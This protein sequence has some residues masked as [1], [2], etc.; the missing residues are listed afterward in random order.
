M[1]R[2]EFFPN[3]G[4]RSGNSRWRKTVGGTALTGEGHSDGSAGP[5]SYLI[6]IWWDDSAKTYRFFTCF[7]DGQGSSCIVRG[8]ARWEGGTFVNEYEELENGKPVK[9]R[10]VFTSLTP[11]SRR[12][13]A[14]RQ[15]ADGSFRTLITTRSVR[16]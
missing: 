8:T 7:K 2:S 16:K 5:L 4:R 13:V 15:S 6:T 1:E 10:D 14:A 12:L 11:T 9:W 3:G